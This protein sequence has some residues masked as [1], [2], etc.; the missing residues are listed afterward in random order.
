M[1]QIFF[2]LLEGEEERGPALK[3]AVVRTFFFTEKKERPHEDQ[4][5]EDRPLLRGVVYVALFHQEPEDDVS[6]RYGGS[7]EGDCRIEIREGVF[8]I[9]MGRIALRASDG[10]GDRVRL[11]R[12]IRDGRRAVS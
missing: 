11:R 1:F 6:N 9:R 4:R 7:R 8:R 3:G 10:L 2:A 12:R 5:R